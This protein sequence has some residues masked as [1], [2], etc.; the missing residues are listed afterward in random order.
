MKESY[1]KGSNDHY[2]ALVKSGRI[3]AANDGI[4]RP[5]TISSGFIRTKQLA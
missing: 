5:M 2:D 3:S 4:T 1:I